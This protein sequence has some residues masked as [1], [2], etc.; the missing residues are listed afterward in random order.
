MNHPSLTSR[1]RSIDGFTLVELL[2]VI[3]IVA[4]LAAVAIGFTQRISARASSATAMSNLRQCGI[5]LMTKASEKNNQ[6]SFFSGGASGGFDQRAYN[7]IREYFGKPQSMWNNEVQNCAELMHWN[8]KRVKPG[9]F[10]WDCYAINFTDVS[11]FG[12]Q[13]RVENGRPDGSNGRVLSVNS[14]TR[15]ESYPILLDSST[16]TGKEIFRVGINGNELPGL[17]NEGK[18]HAFFL[19]GSARALNKADLRKAGFSRAYDNST[20]PPRLITL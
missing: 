9:N 11:D 18:A 7:M 4:I 20:Q 16:S 14:V 19:D 17:R 8:L 6:L 5:I 15:S 3:S 1:R 12:V 13:W 2:V 10:H